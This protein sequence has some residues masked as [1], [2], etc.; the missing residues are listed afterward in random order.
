MRAAR[1]LLDKKL[2]HAT[3]DKLV[4]LMNANNEVDVSALEYTLCDAKSVRVEVAIIDIAERTHS[5]AKT[6]AHHRW[7]MNEAATERN[8]PAMQAAVFYN[9]RE[10][11]WRKY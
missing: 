4:K 7:K 8:I 9:A 6:R 5:A 11:P 10:R 3:K 2:R 1:E